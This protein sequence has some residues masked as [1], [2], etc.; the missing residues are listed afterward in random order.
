MSISYFKVTANYGHYDHTVDL[1]SCDYLED[2]LTIMFCLDFHLV[3]GS[4]FVIVQQFSNLNINTEYTSLP[5]LGKFKD[6]FILGC[7]RERMLANATERI[8]VNGASEHEQTHSFAFGS[9]RSRDGVIKETLPF[10]LNSIRPVSRIRDYID[11][12]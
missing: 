10:S 2:K 3:Y 4:L 5:T 1:F 7:E 8:N 9:F 6:A 11:T 12:Y